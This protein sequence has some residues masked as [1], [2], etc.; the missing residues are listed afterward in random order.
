MWPQCAHA[1][2]A[3]LVRAIQ[4]SAVTGRFVADDVFVTIPI[5]FPAHPCYSHAQPK[6]VCQ[7]CRLVRFDGGDSTLPIEPT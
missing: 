2:M 6:A 4:L 3:R 5:A 7:D 1:V